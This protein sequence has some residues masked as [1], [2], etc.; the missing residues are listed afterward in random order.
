MKK[1]NLLSLGITM[2][3]FFAMSF[4]NPVEAQTTRNAGTEAEF[5]TAY[6]NS[7]TGD[8]INI[9]S[10]IVI[11]GEKTLSK[12]ITINGNGFTITVPNP[13][14]NDMGVFNTSPSTFRVFNISGSVT[15]SINQLTIKGGSVSGGNMDAGCGG[16]ITVALGCTL[17]LNNCIVCNSRVNSFDGGGG[18]NNAG[19]TYLNNSLVIRNASQFGGGFFN[20]GTMFVENSTFS[21]NRSTN[22]INGG[23]GAGENNQGTM[24]FNNSTLSNNQS[25]EIGGGINNNNGGTI[26]MANSSVTGNVCYGS[27]GSGG[28]IGNNNGYVYA[29]NTLFAYNY[30]RTGGDVSDPT[31][32]VLDD[33]VAFSGQNQVFLYYCI[34]HA[35]L[36]GGTNDVIGNINYTGPADG[37]NNTIFSGGDLK[38]ITDGTGTEIGTA[39][40]YRP[41]LYN[42]NNIVAPTLQSGSF[43]FS[44]TGTQTRFANNNNSSPVVAYYNSSTWVNLTGASNSGQLV[45]TDQ[46]GVI[47]RANPPAI[48]AIESATNNLYMVKVNA[49]AYGTVN[50]GTIYGDVYAVGTSVTLTAIPNSGYSFVRWD[51][52]LGGSGTASTDNPY[53][54]TVNGNIT[55]VPVFTASSSGYNITYVG[56]GNTGGTAPASGNYSG[57]TTIS[58]P[59]ISL[60]KSGYVFN[61]WNT[62]SNGSGTSY[63]QGSAYSAGVNLT[64]YAQWQVTYQPIITTTAISAVTP[65]SATSGG[66]VIYD[67][68]YAVTDRGVCWN[69][70]GTPTLTDNHTD[71]TTDGTGTGSYSS[72]ITGLSISNTYYVRAYATNSIGTSYGSELVILYTSP[73]VTTTA[74]SSITPT[75]AISGGS[76]TNDGNSAVTARGVCWN[77]AGTPTITDTHTTNGSGTGVYSSSIASLSAGTRY[78][79]RAYATNSIGTSYGAELSFVASCTVFIPDANFLAALIAD[80]FTL[81][82][83]GILCSEAAAYTGTLDVSFQGISDLTGIE[84]FTQLPVLNCSFNSLTSLNVTDNTALTE[85][86]CDDNALTSLDVTHNTLLAHL[87]CE[88]NQLT[89]L[90]VSSNTALTYLDCSF[91][92]ISSLDVST[93]T[94]LQALSCNNNSLI[95]LDVQNGNNYY[96]SVFDATN[97]PNLSCIQVD[98][99]TYSTAN[100]TNI[101]AGASFGTNCACLV[102]I[103]DANFLN[104]LIAIGGL[105][106]GHGEIECSLAAAYTGTLDVSSQGISDLTGIEAFTQI[107]GLNCSLNSLTSLNVSAN[108]ALTDLECDGNALTSLDVTHNTVLAQMQCE[109]NQ[110]TSLNVSGLT[111]L[112]YLLCNNNQLTTLNVSTNTDLS[113]LE[114][115]NNSITGLNVS[116]NTALATLYCNNNSLTSLN[117]SL[118]TALTDLLCNDNHLISLDASSNTLL[119]ILYCYNNSLSSLDVH[120]NTAL[121]NFACSQNS[122]TSLNVK[123]GNNTLF[124]YFDATNNA[125]LSCIQVD[126]VAWSTT[127]WTSG[128]GNIDA[129]ASFSTNCPPPASWIGVTSINWSVGTN[130]YTGIVPTATDDVIIPPGTPYSPSVDLGPD[131]PAVCNNIIIYS[132]AVLTIEAG[133]AFTVHGTTTLNGTEC[134]ILKSDAT[135]TASFI[136]NGTITY[137]TGGSAMVEKYMDNSRWWY[138]GSPVA[139]CTGADAF[140]SLSGISG[141]GSRLMW[142]DE[143]VADTLLT[144]YKPVQDGDNLPPLKGYA[145]K[146][147]TASYKLATFKGNLNTNTISVSNLPRTAPGGTGVG[148]YKNGYNLV[149][150]PYP[151]A[152]NLGNNAGQYI[153]STVWYKRNSSIRFATY[154]WLDG[155]GLLNGGTSTIPAMQAFWVRVAKGNSTGGITVT[156]AMRCHS[157]NSNYKL[158]DPSNV[159]RMEIARDTMIDELAVAFFAA[160]FDT[161]DDYDSQKMFSD[162]N[163]DPQLYSLTTD[164]EK[165]AINGQSELL[166]GVERIVPLGFLT[167][168]AGNF[169]ITATNLNDFDANTSVYLEDTQLNIIQDLRQSNLYSFTSGITDNVSRFRLHFGAAPSTINNDEGTSAI[170]IYSYDNSVYVNSPIETKGSV[171][172]YDMLGKLIM[173]SSLVQ[174]LNKVQLS[175]VNGIYIVKVQT[176]D[177][178]ITHKVIIGK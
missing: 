55:L 161:L 176:K 63:A 171:E 162:N 39:F 44:N 91:N 150:N 118:N 127:N 104:A 43:L 107:T 158:T 131:P 57:T 174:G 109:Y 108:T 112:Y 40:V 21:E 133:K 54:F 62:N 89:S 98:D 51:Y 66:I 77:I 7:T 33:I 35:S 90:N 59:D 130:W 23:G 68:G 156:N 167:Y 8:I 2:V 148:V 11:T 61:G 146:E 163:G 82:G 42:N 129:G 164:N 26:Y 50:G 30:F 95:N 34:Y 49:S 151:S 106:N 85:M 88:N 78:Y 73:T 121:T 92:S 84:A 12:T 145:F 72:S 149:S 116:S 87:Q 13:G 28:G 81:N 9:T 177:E 53:T 29:V 159:F 31:A 110:L 18:I 41:Y 5:N 101:D 122:L 142:Y 173:N 4:L 169:T 120:L 10:N 74:I 24:Y 83:Y 139:S 75:S 69:T 137:G 48:G 16:A 1:I 56:N 65:T 45:T 67:G 175:L 99:P 114:C 60:V 115:N 147:F 70:T 140:G 119:Q 111:S 20:S 71:H 47:T 141:Q 32:Y 76:V 103:P 153:E 58:A 157:T 46:V 117:V 6:T 19:V 27:Y 100:W 126:D 135:G 165:V 155:I 96:F 86:E 93:N 37:T 102:Y 17:H 132:G 168:V 170:A 178:L 154:N 138:I 172:V 79:V 36:P 52:V 143:T 152:I 136:D 144:A 105:D 14:L 38:K 128:N 97:N 123:N 113:D 125:G 3:M 80:G 25:T 94:A 22:T 64:L 134:L 124:Y 166:P 160:A 15:L